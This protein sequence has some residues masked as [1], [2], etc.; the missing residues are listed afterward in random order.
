MTSISTSGHCGECDGP[1]HQLQVDLIARKQR[2]KPCGH[3]AAI[4]FRAV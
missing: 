3:T 4:V 1:V 2:I